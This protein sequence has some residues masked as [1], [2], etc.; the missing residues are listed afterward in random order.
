MNGMAQKE[1]VLSQPSVPALFAARLFGV[2]YWLCEQNTVP[3]KATVMFA[4]K[5]RAIFATFED[6]KKFVKPFVAAKC[7]TVGNPVRTKVLSP[8]DTKDA[9][10]FFSLDHC[11]KVLLVIGGSQ[12]A[13]ALNELV[14][15][16]K[17][18]Y[19]DEFSRIGVI[20]CTGAQSFA[21]YRAVAREQKGMGSIYISP[22]VEDVGLAYRAADIAISRSGAGV[23]AELALLGVPSILIPYPYAAADHQNKNAD[24]FARS[25]ASVKINNK[26][27]TASVIAPMI[28]DIL[29]SEQKLSRMRKKSLAEAFPNSARDIIQAVIQ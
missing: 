25:G 28:L 17:T 27:A 14:V 16:M 19:A 23:M 13:L 2:P 22:F 5:A 3:G 1:Q 18:K 21:K 29:S 4:K 15:A 11:D 7:V 8:I 24:V 20:W 26:D 10:K 12:G 9:R 6:T